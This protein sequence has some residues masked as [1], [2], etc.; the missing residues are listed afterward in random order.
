MMYVLIV[1]DQWDPGDVEAVMG[2]FDDAQAARAKYREVFGDKF[3]K[4]SVQKIV[5]G[6]PEWSII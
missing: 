6:L 3:R 2:P 4:S 1:F 5:D